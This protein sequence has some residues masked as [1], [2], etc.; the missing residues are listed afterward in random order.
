MAANCESDLHMDSG[1]SS[2]ILE[3]QISSYMSEIR[4]ERTSS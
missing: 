4:G 1:S 3:N 2:K